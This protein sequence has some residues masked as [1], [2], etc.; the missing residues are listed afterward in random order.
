[1]IKDLK[2]RKLNTEKN[3]KKQQIKEKRENNILMRKF[4]T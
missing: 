2:K 3:K 4:I 1:M